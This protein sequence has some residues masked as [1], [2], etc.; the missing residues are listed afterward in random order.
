[1]IQTPSQGQ[2][3]NL[4]SRF[5]SWRSKVAL[6]DGRD[7]MA[8]GVDVGNL[9]WPVL[10]FFLGAV[11]VIAVQLWQGLIVRQQPPLLPEVI[12]LA[13][14]VVAASSRAS[15]HLWGITGLALLAIAL[16]VLLDAMTR[17]DW[18]N[19]GLYVVIAT[20]L[21]RL[22]P[23]FSIPIFAICATVI[24]A[25]DGLFD[26]IRGNGHVNGGNI[27]SQ[28]L[29]I[30]FAFSASL[31]Q[32][33]RRL[34]INQ[35]EQTQAQLREEMGRAADLAAAR[36]RARI[37]R[38]VHDVLAHSLTVLSVQ[39]QALR[40]LVHD[41]PERAE[42]MLEQMAEV[43]RES[44]VE[45]RQIVGLLREA[46]TDEANADSAT[47]LRVLAERFD[48]RTGMRCTLREHG[49]PVHLPA[50][51]VEAL[52]FGMQEALTNAYRHGKAT[53]AEADLW[54][55]PESVRLSV[56]DDGAG[57]PS[58]TLGTIATIAA[59]S[60]SEGS[61]NGLRGMRERAEALGGTMEARQRPDGL[62]F[63]V[64]LTLPL[65]VERE[66]LPSPDSETGQDTEKT[67]SRIA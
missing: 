39:V 49:N 24:L 61:G 47:R 21:Y 34:L 58:A 29:I 16:C 11:I 18:G 32:R 36:E 55:E 43:L 3:G 62:G 46:I 52:R 19:I 27:I 10:I 63:S 56:C 9:T 50:Q 54:W 35:L 6:L 45:S 4:P 22:P 65:A 57:V 26:L 25:A 15:R 51:H 23:R 64:T 30:G 5:R 33:I 53:H 44:Q 38:D 12:F 41:S 13:G 20:V 31:A 37:A 40:Q 66:A 2:P 59:S 14:L 28:V 48:E 60:A 17:S 1:M 7:V 67:G 8:G 42:A